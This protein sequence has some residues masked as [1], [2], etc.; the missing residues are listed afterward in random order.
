MIVHPG[1]VEN[2]SISKTYKQKV[3]KLICFSC[4]VHEFFCVL[5]AHSIAAVE[6][7]FFCVNS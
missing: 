4:V 7:F 2:I 5:G 6:Y 1:K 3:E